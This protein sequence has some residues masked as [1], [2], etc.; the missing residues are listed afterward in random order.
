MSTAPSTSAPRPKPFALVAVEQPQ[1]ERGGRDPD[2]DVHEEDPVPV[3]GLGEHAAGEQADRRAGRRHERVDADRLRLLPRLGEHRDDHPEDHGRRHRA[4]DALDEAGRDQ[5]LLALGEAAQQ[6]G[7]GEDA[8]PGEEDAAARDEVAEPAGQ[9]QQP[10]EGDQVRVD[11]PGEAGLRE[12]EVAPGSR[13]AR[14]S[15]PWR[16]GRSSAS[17]RTARTSAIQRDRSGLE[18]CHAGRDPYRRPNSSEVTCTVDAHRRGRRRA[19]PA[20]GRPGGQRAR[21]RA[22]G[23]ALPPGAARALLPDA[24]LG[25]RRRGRAAGRAA[26]RVARA[27]ALRG[28]QLAALVALH[29]RHEHLP[30][31]AS[32]AGPSGCCRSTTARSSDPHDGAGQPLVESVWVEPYPDET[33]GLEDGYA[34][35]EARYELRESVELAFVAALQ[36]LPANQRAVLILREVLG[37]SAQEVAESLDTTVASVN[38]ALQ[39][40]RK[41]VDE[42]LPERSQQ[43]TLRAL[44]DERLRELVERYMDAMQRGDVDARRRHA[45]RGRGAGRCRRWPSWYRGPT[46]IADFLA[47]GPLS[48]ASRWRHVPAHAN[49][50]AAVGGY[51]WHEDE[52]AYLAVRPRRADARRASEDQGGH[53]RSSRARSRPRRASPSSAPRPARR[54]RAGRGDLRAPRAAGPAGLSG[55]RPSRRTA[56]PRS[57]EFAPRRRSCPE[58]H[59]LEGGEHSCSRTAR[60]SAASPWTTSTRRAAVLR[61]HA[62]AQDV[63]DVEENGLLTLHLAGRP[64]HADL[65][66]AGLRRR[67]PTRS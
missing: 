27:G 21:L 22:P 41:T 47:G 51:T 44:G 12:A 66:Q 24:R 15:R 26:A 17:R 50:Q 25:P 43:A 34:A 65:P 9:Q 29:D 53:A 60:R 52:Q 4:A 18:R 5:H 3:D 6:R 62:R 8:E 54:P 14:R 32:R 59:R 30:E 49:G 16:R 19:R 28:P 13:A 1:C 67:R 11:D 10:A 35:P 38:S 48:G 57:D 40:A 2:R 58:T 20:E 7:D 64:H 31:P 23:R 37:F 45:R 46:T 42:R 61:R 63:R 36:H 39:R 56:P 55:P 33:L